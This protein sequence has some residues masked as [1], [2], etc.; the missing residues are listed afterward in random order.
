LKV[1]KEIEGKKVEEA[2]D[3]STRF[4]GPGTNVSID[5][6]LRFDVFEIKKDAFPHYESFNGKNRVI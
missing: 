5:P 4:L 2:E 3:G 1:V 6:F